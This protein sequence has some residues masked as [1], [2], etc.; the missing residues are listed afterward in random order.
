M[1]PGGGT[2]LRAL[3]RPAMFLLHRPGLENIARAGGRTVRQQRK[4]RLA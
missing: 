1:T 2:M 4:E 3:A